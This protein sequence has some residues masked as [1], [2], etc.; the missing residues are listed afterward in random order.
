MTT[1]RITRGEVIGVGTVGA[2]LGIVATL[3]TGFVAWGGLEARTKTLE[4]AR[5][6]KTEREALKEQITEFRTESRGRFD[7]LE[8]ILLERK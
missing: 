3:G 6:N 1:R 4:A 5:I 7:R 8:R 2:I